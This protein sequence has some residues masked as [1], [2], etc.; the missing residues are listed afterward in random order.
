[1]TP[2]DLLGQFVEAHVLIR[3]EN[4]AISGREGQLV[5]Q[6][7]I[8]RWLSPRRAEAEDGNAA[9]RLDGQIFP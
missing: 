5:S 4:R 8:S 2:I 1:M 3:G 9:V 7:R 6:A